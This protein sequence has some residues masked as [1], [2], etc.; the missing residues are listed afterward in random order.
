M[1]FLTRTWLSPEEVIEAIHKLTGNK[2]AG[3]DSIIPE[4]FKHSCKS[5]TPFLVWL[6]N[7]VFSSG[8]YPEAWTEALI[9]PLLKKCSVLNPDNYRGIS[10]LNICNKLYCSIINTRVS[11]WVEEKNT[12]GEMQAGFRKDHYTIDHKL[13]SHFLLWFRNIYWNVVCCLYR[14]P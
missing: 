10:L 2:A 7:K 4:T 14:F 13:Y 6:F 9:H 5:I 3:P 12:L 1:T 8:E 11:R